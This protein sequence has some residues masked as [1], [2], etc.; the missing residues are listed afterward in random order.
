MTP[1]KVV[2]LPL[3]RPP[4]RAAVLPQKAVAPPTSPGP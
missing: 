2:V 1:P 3:K 4:Q